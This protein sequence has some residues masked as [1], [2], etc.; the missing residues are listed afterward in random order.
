M[1]FKYIINF[2]F[3]SYISFYVACAFVICLIKYL[4]TYLLTY[5]ENL[6]YCTHGPYK[7]HHIEKRV[8][9]LFFL[10]YY[11]VQRATSR[12]AINKTRCGCSGSN[13]GSCPAARR[14]KLRAEPNARFISLLSAMAQADRTISVLR[15][16]IV[17][18]CANG[19]YYSKCST[20]RYSQDTKSVLK[21]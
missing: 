6:V 7:T 18:A 4:L 3:L 5:N 1:F 21:R 20:I 17:V 10:L 16:F 12:T 13:H 14:L 11:V 8:A 9:R 2:Y 15:C 19:K